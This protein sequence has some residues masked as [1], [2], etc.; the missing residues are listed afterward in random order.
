MNVTA[1]P[2][3]ASL[4][5]QARDEDVAVV[6]LEGCRQRR[7]PARPAHTPLC[8][9]PADQAYALR[10]RRAGAARGRR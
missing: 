2:D 3:L 5:R 9:L 4:V 7:H 1:N 6:D 8:P 10:W